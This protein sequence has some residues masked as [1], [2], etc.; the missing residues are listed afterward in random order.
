MFPTFYLLDFMTFL[1]YLLG[2]LTATFFHSKGTKF[3]FIIQLQSISCRETNKKVRLGRK[4]TEY[5]NHKKGTERVRLLNFS[6]EI[7]YLKT[8]EVKW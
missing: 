7:L 5:L 1:F 3:V 4:G 6:A 2:C 8:E